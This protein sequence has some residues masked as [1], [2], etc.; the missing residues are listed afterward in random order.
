[1]NTLIIQNIE[2]EIQ[3]NKDIRKFKHDIQN[4]FR[5]LDYLDRQNGYKLYNELKEEFSQFENIVNT[6]NVYIDAIINS[7]YIIK[8]S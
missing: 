1:M 6:G 2:Q 3:N 5:A 8:E 7:K 4:K